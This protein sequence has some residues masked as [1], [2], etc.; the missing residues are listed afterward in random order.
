[1][2]QQS[3]IRYGLADLPE[4]SGVRFRWRLRLRLFQNGP[5]KLRQPQFDGRPSGPLAKTRLHLLRCDSYGAEDFYNQVPRRLPDFSVRLVHDGFHLSQ[6]SGSPSR[7]GT[8]LLEHVI[9]GFPDR[10]DGRRQLLFSRR[11]HHAGGVSVTPGSFLGISNQKGRRPRSSRMSR[12]TTTNPSPPL[13][14]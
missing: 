4:R 6:K 9:D 10:V 2:A 8:V 3:P 7:E 13:G 14:P 11:H 12:I 5:G 1:M